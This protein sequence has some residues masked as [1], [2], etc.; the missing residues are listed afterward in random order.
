MV[1]V[2]DQPPFRRAARTL[3]ELD[4]RFT[5]VGEAGSGEEALDLVLALG[6][7]LVLMDVALPGINGIEAARLLCARAPGSRVV[8]VSTRRRSDLPPGADDC[9]A[10]AFV[11]KEELDPDVL[12]ALVT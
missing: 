5:V 9:G 2:D 7:G 6:P 8:L 11:A 3:L 4:G 1:I 12:V 10:L